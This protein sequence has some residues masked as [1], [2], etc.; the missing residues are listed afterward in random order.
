ME[1]EA[2]IAQGQ[3]M[4]VHSYVPS[5]VHLKPS[6][7]C[8]TY[9]YA[10][11]VR[12]TEEGGVLLRIPQYTQSSYQGGLRSFLDDFI[13]DRLLPRLKADVNKRVADITDGTEAFKLA[14]RWTG[15]LADNQP[16][17]AVRPLLPGA[18]TLLQVMQDLFKALRAMTPYATELMAVAEIILLSYFDR[19]QREY[20]GAVGNS[21]ASSSLSSRELMELYN[22]D[23][24]FRYL[25]R[26]AIFAADAVGAPSDEAVRSFCMN[27][28]TIEMRLGFHT[29]SGCPLTKHDLMPSSQSGFAILASLAESLEWLA[30]QLDRLVNSA[31]GS[32]GALSVSLTASPERMDL[33]K[34]PLRKW[35]L[36]KPDRA[37]SFS[38]DLNR[39]EQDLPFSPESIRVHTSK[40]R[41]LAKLCLFTLRLEIRCHCFYF[42]DG[43]SKLSYKADEDGDDSERYIGHLTKDINRIHE[44]LSMILSY[45]K[46]SYLFGG[47]A[48]LIEEAMIMALVKIQDINPNGVLKMC[49]NVYALQLDL[50]SVISSQETNFD[51]V[52]RYYELLNLSEEAFFTYVAEHPTDF[53]IE[54]LNV[55]I[56]RRFA[57]PNATTRLREALCGTKN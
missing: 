12:F 18:K 13:Q 31:A 10:P 45:A 38:L 54:T 51:R 44:T 35:L 26:L 16:S 17:T 27:E 2:Q 57:S 7:Y 20:A 47:I 55:I 52:R 6:P 37:G 14:D 11:L 39:D 30:S 40:F 46:T 56:Q 23:P 22:A 8:L 50:P 34:I 43:V 15:M 32:E 3:A 36:R 9:V 42:L 4:S 19:C 5:G 29:P 49:R 21:Y 53:S 25:E 41:Q 1:L 24:H 48:L 28:R 33:T